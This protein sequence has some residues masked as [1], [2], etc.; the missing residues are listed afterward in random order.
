[1]FLREI[2]RIS[3]DQLSGIVSPMFRIL[4]HAISEYHNLFQGISGIY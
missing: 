1:M 3:K 4:S 2:R